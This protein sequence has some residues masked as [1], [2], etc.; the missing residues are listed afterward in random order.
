MNRL[1]M[2]ACCALVLVST[3]T[4][5]EVYKWKDKAG[6]VHYSDAPPTGN[7]PYTT[8]SGQKPAEVAVPVVTKDQPAQPAQATTPDDEAKRK[9]AEELAAKERAA[10]DA[11]L[12]RLQEE[13]QAAER[14]M[15]EENCKN[16]RARAAQFQHGGR[17]SYVDEEG[18]RQFYGDAEIA[19]ELERARVDI[20]T[21]CH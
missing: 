8:L 7:I 17:I 20:E 19:A 2:A 9:A 12:K 14:R 15:R 4:A 1:M 5:A 21:Y 10:K 16:A 11:E 18:K 13:K 6:K 3:S